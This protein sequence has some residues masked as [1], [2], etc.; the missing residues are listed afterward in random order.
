M[1]IIF[2]GI[3]F[4]DFSTLVCGNYYYTYTWKFYNIIDLQQDRNSKFNQVTVGIQ[5]F[6][7]KRERVRRASA[8]LSI[9]IRII[10]LMWLMTFIRT[11]M[12]HYINNEII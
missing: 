5:Y 2:F 11:I 12:S 9:T 7:L 6:I 10:V 8:L 1:K 4:A 3:I